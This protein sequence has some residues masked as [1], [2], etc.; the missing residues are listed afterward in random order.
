MYMVHLRVV[1]QG[2]G[3][4]KSRKG[5]TGKS[6]PRVL[7][8]I[9]S[10]VKGLPKPLD[11]WCWWVHWKEHEKLIIIKKTKIF[12]LKRHYI[13][14]YIGTREREREKKTKN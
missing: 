13:I 11:G 14:H 2:L 1:D 6:G 4:K 10:T 3:V 5:H 8:T 7:S 12:F 9:E